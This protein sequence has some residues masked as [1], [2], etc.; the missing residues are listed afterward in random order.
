MRKGTCKKL[1]EA[2]EDVEWG[3]GAGPGRGTG[4]CAGAEGAGGDGRFLGRRR[5]DC[6]GAVDR[7][8]LL[9]EGTDVSAEDRGTAD[10]KCL[11]CVMR[12]C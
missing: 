1:V 2:G 3:R 9:L 4:V 7:A 5:P 11:R 12:Y 6:S 10:D 8:D